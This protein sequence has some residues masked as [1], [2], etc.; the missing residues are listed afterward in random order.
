METE[1]VEKMNSVL[2][3]VLLERLIQDSYGYTPEHDDEHGVNHILAEAVNRLGNS[4]AFSHGVVPREEL[5]K[6]AALVVAAIEATD[7]KA[8][9]G[10]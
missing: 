5:I 3:E 7:R 2:G 10:L 6:I 8:E 1:Q 9:N 4:E